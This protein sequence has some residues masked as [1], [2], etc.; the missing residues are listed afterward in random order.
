VLGNFA[1]AIFQPAEHTAIGASTAVF[2]GIAILAVL[3]WR[4]GSRDGRP[5]VSGLAARLRQFAPLIAGATLLAFLGGGN[6]DGRIDVVGHVAG[7]GAGLAVGLLVTF[8]RRWLPER[9]AAQI[10]AGLGALGALTVSWIAA[11][12]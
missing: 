10:L 7:F 11:L 4:D 9:R 2:A 12:A 1:G 8:G 3:G 6:G 5:F